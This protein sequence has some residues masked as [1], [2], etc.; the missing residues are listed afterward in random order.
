MYKSTNSELLSISYLLAVAFTLVHLKRVWICAGKGDWV[1]WKFK[2][3]VFFTYGEC[4]W[5]T[6][7]YLIKRFWK[8]NIST[9]S[10]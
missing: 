10:I 2:I 4:V 1:R 6:E 9:P 7:N 5:S 8:I 3:V